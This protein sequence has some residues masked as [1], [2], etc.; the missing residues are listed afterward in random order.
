MFCSYLNDALK[1]KELKQKMRRPLLSI[2]YVYIGANDVWEIVEKGYK[3]SQNEDSLRIFFKSSN[4]FKLIKKMVKS[5]K[6]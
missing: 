4:Y 5:Y 2:I 3:E 6:M 1:V